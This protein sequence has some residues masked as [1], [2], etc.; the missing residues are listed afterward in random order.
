MDTWDEYVALHTDAFGYPPASRE[1]A[2]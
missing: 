2:D 1:R